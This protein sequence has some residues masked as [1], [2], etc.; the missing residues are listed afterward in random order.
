[1]SKAFCVGDVVVLKGGGPCMTVLSV[2]PDDYVHVA[3][4]AEDGELT[5]G[6]FHDAAL[7]HYKQQ[8]PRGK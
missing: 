1:M 2:R 8:D 6:A 4:F 3:W 7:D 5:E